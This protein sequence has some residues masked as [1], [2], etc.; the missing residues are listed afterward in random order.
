M[1]QKPVLWVNVHNCVRGRVFRKR[2]NTEQRGSSEP[3]KIAYDLITVRPEV[4]VCHT[5]CGM[6]IKYL[7]ASPAPWA[8]RTLLRL[9]QEIE[10]SLT[11]GP[12]PKAK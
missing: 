2:H 6:A 3:M 9:R 1:V 8:S 10:K 11:E 7:S 5:D 4:P 12:L